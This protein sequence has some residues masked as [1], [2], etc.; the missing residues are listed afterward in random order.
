MSLSTRVG[1]LEERYPAPAAGPWVVLIIVHDDGT[2]VHLCFTDRPSETVTLR[3]Y[4][5]RYPGGLHGSERWII[6]SDADP[7]EDRISSYEL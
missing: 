7:I 6:L 2:N 5:Q 4:R 1:R 3:E